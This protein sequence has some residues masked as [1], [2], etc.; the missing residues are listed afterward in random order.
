VNLLNNF[1]ATSTVF[2]LYLFPRVLCNLVID[3][4]ICACLSK[5]AV[6]IVLVLHFAFNLVTI[7]FKCQNRGVDFFGTEGV[8]CLVTF[9][10]L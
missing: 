10:C 6:W 1:E 7:C 2:T 5:T 8:L 4:T 3:E 9:F